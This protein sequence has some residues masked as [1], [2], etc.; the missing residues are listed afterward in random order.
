MFQLYLAKSS[1][2]RTSNVLN[3]FQK[4]NAIFLIFPISYF[5]LLYKVQQLFPFLFLFLI[6][7][8]CQTD[9]NSTF[10]LFHPRLTLCH[11]R[12]KNIVPRGNDI[13]SFHWI[14]DLPQ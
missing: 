9:Q 7:Q 8:Y 11:T 14:H 1:F 3:S 5:H 4:K 6:N 2:N 10:S 13:Q 12:D